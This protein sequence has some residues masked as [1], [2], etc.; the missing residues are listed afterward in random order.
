MHT[1]LLFAINFPFFKKS[2]FKTVK[3]QIK[4]ILNKTAYVREVTEYYIDLV[5]TY[6]TAPEMPS[7]DADISH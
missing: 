1:E 6:K 2:H 5:T 3:Y 7:L 4:E